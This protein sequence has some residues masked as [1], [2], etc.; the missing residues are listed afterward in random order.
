MKR[1]N[2]HKNNSGIALITA[3]MFTLIALGIILATYQLVQRGTELSGLFKRYRTA[4]EA[5]MGSY[6]FF[7]KEFIVKTLEGETLNLND[8]TI[9][10][11]FR[12]D[13]PISYTCIRSK[14]TTSPEAGGYTNC[15]G[16]STDL[17]PTVSPDLIF[18]F[19]P[20]IAYLKV[21]DTAEGN[22]EIGGTPLAGSGV[23]EAGTTFITPPHI[24]YLYRIDI[25]AQRQGGAM[26]RAWLTGLYCY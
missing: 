6:E 22:S 9:S 3:L 18:H 4:M 10:Q 26:E 24:P 14:L 21:T 20:F 13:E 12:P 5:A 1:Y 25:L 7:T 15:Q 16:N 23:V 2:I 8:P 17:N 19:D 11:V